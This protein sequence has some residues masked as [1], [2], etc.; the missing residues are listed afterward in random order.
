MRNHQPVQLSPWPR[1]SPAEVSGTS[2]HGS[3]R[4]AALDPGRDVALGRV[5]MPPKVLPSISLPFG[6]DSVKPLPIPGFPFLASGAHGPPH[7]SPSA[8]VLALF[9]GLGSVRAHV[10][11]HQ[12]PSLVSLRRTFVP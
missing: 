5:S 11:G 7:P 3:S 9:P 1:K 6:F 12:A 2:A 10:L 8:G 4:P